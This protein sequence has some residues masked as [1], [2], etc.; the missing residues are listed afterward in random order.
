MPLKIS[1]RYSI[2][3]LLTP[4][5]PWGSLS[6]NDTVEQKFCQ[7]IKYILHE[8]TL[9]DKEENSGPPTRG[10]MRD[11]EAGLRNAAQN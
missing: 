10:V 3:Q 8:H 9:R 7:I 1:K 4:I 6:L 5:K 2:L 11:C